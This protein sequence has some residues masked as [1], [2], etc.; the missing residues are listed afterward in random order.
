MGGA[1]R[2]VGRL[3][4]SAHGVESVAEG[5]KVRSV[6]ADGQHHVT[7]IVSLPCRAIRTSPCTKRTRFSQIP[8]QRTQRQCHLRLRGVIS[9]DIFG[10]YPPAI[11]TV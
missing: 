2:S 1:G 7:S 5:I 9:I 8:Q 6:P 3:L 4:I 11:T 10:L